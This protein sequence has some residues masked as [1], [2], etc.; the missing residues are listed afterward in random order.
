MGYVKKIRS[1]TLE[2]FANFFLKIHDVMI[3]ISYG[4]FN[5]VYQIFDLFAPN[6]MQYFPLVCNFI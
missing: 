3:T 5:D 1:H 6:I 2:Q 4:K